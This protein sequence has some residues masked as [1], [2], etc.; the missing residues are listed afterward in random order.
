MRSDSP[1]MPRVVLTNTA[2]IIFLLKINTR[3]ILFVG[4]L[5]PL[6][7]SIDCKEETEVEA[8]D[9]NDIDDEYSPDGLLYISMES[10]PELFPI[11]T[12]SSILY[13]SRTE[14][15]NSFSANALIRHI[16]L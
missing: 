8:F 1:F 12:R 4:S 14:I 13:D 6:A 5:G 10:S 9:S 2:G 15:K 3:S 7:E 11:R 16:K